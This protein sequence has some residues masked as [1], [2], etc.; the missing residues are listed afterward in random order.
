MRA[1]MCI[2]TLHALN[3]RNNR[4]ALLNGHSDVAE[5]LRVV[6]TEPVVTQE[7]LAEDLKGLGIEG[8]NVTMQA[9]FE[10][11]QQRLLEAALASGKKTPH[12]GC[13][14]PP[15]CTMFNILGPGFVFKAWS[16][17]IGSC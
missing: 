4:L 11:E 5:L 1:E 17:G 15:P 7:S 3:A 6:T 2:L 8:K 9:K 13:W 12:P 10:M 16:V 14:P